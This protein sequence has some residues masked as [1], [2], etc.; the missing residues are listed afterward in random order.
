MVNLTTAWTKIIDSNE[1]FMFSVRR[2]TVRFRY[3]SSAP[4]AETEVGSD[5]SAGEHFGVDS[6]TED[7]YVR[8]IGDATAVIC[9]HKE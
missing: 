4:G 9:L 1:T 6:P 8:A 7:V 5:F 3:S 2:G